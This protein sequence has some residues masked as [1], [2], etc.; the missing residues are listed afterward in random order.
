[1]EDTGTQV[2]DGHWWVVNIG[3]YKKVLDFKVGGG[4]LGGW[5]NLR[6]VVEF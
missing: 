2:G 6:S 3:W 1:M 4:I 5:W